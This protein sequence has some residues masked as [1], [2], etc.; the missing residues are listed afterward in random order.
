MK[1]IGL[2]QKKGTTEFD[3]LAR[4][5]QAYIDE[6]EDNPVTLFYSG[7]EGYWYEPE[8]V[9]LVLVAIEEFP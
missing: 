1:N 3:T 6:V 8:S 9:A 7:P 5:A 4:C 2:P